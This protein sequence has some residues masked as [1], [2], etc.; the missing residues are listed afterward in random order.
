MTYTV[1][2]DVSEQTMS[3]KGTY[4]DKVAIQ[5]SVMGRRTAGNWTGTT[6]LQDMGEYLTSSDT[7][8]N[9][10][11]AGVLM[12]IVSTSTDDDGSPVGIGAQ[13]VHVVF[14][15][16]NNDLQEETITMNGTTVVETLYRNSI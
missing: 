3:I 1:H 8:F 5:V 16:T 9:D 15:D 6:A 13:T 14:L 4:N 10:S 12:S 11:S 2:D 7:A